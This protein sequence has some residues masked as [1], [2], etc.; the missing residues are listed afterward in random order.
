M[1][2]KGNKDYQ[3]KIL[4][5]PNVLSFFRLCLIPLIIWLY[6]FKEEY[7]LT[8]LVYGVSGLTDVIDGAIARKFNMIS[9]FGKIFDP[10][11]DKLTQMAVI[12]CLI[13]NFWY[14]AIPLAIFVIKEVGMGVFALVSVKKT[15]VIKGSNW[16]GKVST[17]IF[18]ILMVLHLVWREIPLEVSLIFVSV[19]T[20]MMILSAILYT[21]G[22][23]KAIKA[24]HSSPEISDAEQ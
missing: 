16:H 18:F 17:V 14:M 15:H 1:S 11:A 20:A 21:V 2:N 10:I 24:S 6:C 23:V 9:N 7:V 22:Y 13:T 5:I 8:I 19:S 3:D 4:T 12:G